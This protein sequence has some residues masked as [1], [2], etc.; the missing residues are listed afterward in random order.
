MREVRNAIAC[1]PE[2]STAIRRYVADIENRARLTSPKVA[3]Y[4]E[5]QE[6]SGSATLSDAYLRDAGGAPC[7][8]WGTQVSV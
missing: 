4:A 1:Q 8:L 3:H 5:S 7:P 2:K 6:W